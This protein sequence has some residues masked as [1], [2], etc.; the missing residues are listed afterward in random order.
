MPTYITYMAIYIKWLEATTPIVVEQSMAEFQLECKT[1][2]VFSWRYQKH[3]NSYKQQLTPWISGKVT[4]GNISS[5]ILSRV[6]DRG[7]LT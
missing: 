5:T 1:A 6:G 7:P 3:R 2:A 4:F